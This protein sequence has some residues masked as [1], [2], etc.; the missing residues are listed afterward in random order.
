MDYECIMLS[1]YIT[2]TKKN[3][4]AYILPYL[5]ALKFLCQLFAKLINLEK[6]ELVA[7]IE[8]VSIH[9]HI[10]TI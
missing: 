10:C 2:S 8:L 4:K 1:N 5:N 3:N 6:K 9:Q 7:K